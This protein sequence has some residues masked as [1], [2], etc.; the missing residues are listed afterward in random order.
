MGLVLNLYRIELTTRFYRN[1]KGRMV[2]VIGRY[3]DIFPED[4]Y[5]KTHPFINFLHEYHM[6]VSKNYKVST[7]NEQINFDYLIKL[8]KT[9]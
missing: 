7:F 5:G 3:E 9:L 4:K 6:Q 1:H 8:N 2:N